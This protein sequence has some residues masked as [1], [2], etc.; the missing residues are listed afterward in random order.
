MLVLIAVRCDQKRSI[1]A[2]IVLRAP[3]RASH[4]S[5]DQQARELFDR[6]KGKFSSALNRIFL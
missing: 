5:I 1:G 6:R 2:L 4:P 3:S